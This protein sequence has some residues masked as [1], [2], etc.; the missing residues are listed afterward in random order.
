MSLNHYCSSL[1]Q[2]ISKENEKTSNEKHLIENNLRF[3]VQ[4]AHKFRGRL[5]LEDLIQWGNM[6]LMDA[7]K[8]FNPD[9]NIR[10][11]S[12]AVHYIREYMRRGI[13]KNCLIAHDRYHKS[14]FIYMDM[15]EPDNGGVL[16]H[17]DAMT[18]SDK[19]NRYNPVTMINMR[20]D[21]NKIEKC[22][23]MLPARL[24]TVIKCRYGLEGQKKTTLKEIGR[25][26]KLHAVNIHMMEKRA[27]K[28]M[29]TM[30][31]KEC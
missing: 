13:R 3:V 27:L 12:F 14:Q 5:P 16:E 20:E 21:F 23:K 25:M 2:P 6:G 7:A 9:K 29:K 28:M 15:V 24:A 17:D 8:K 11:I 30:M 1:Q 26:F 31:E 18:Y 19:M 4:V 22:V 10:F